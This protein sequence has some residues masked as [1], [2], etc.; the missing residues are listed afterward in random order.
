MTTAAQTKVVTGVVRLSYVNIFEPV[1]KNGKEKFS[2]TLL[3][4]KKDKATLDKIRAAQEAAAV[5]KWP[6]KRPAK[7]AYTLHDG[8]GPRP[9]D[10]EA[11]GAECKGHFVLSVASNEKPG[12]IDS[13]S[14]PILDKFEVKSGDYARVSINAY[15]FEAEGK[16]GVS[17]GLQNIMKV[18]DGESLSGRSRAE[19]DFKDFVGKDDED[20]ESLY[21]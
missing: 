18:R 9:S 21:D 15:G 6:N 19:D 10:G 4:P 7:L 12:V 11:F 3:I 20:D 17:F 5:K 1:V 2:T 16:K 14:N 8:D 13:A